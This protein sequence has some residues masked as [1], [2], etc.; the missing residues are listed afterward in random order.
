LK[1]WRYSR[2]DGS[3]T[4]FSLDADAAL[5]ALSDLLMEGLSADEALSWMERG[6]FDLAGLDMRV[7]GLDE[8]LAELRDEQRRLEQRYRLDEADRDLRRRL[9]EILDRE[10]RAQRER[11]GYESQRMNEF[12]ER[13]H[14]ESVQRKP[15]EK[16]SEAIERFRD[17][18]FADAEAGREFQALLDELDRLR[19]LEQFVAQRGRRFRGS[20]AADYQTAQRIRERI[21]ALEQLARDLAAGNFETLDA[22]QLRELLSESGMRSLILIRDLRS[23][24]E[25][26]GY[27]RDRDGNAELTP[28]AIRRIGAQALATV[29]GALRK[30]RPGAHETTQQ[31]IAVPR[32]DE[33]RPWQFGDAFDVDVVKS[34]L[35]AVK[36]RSTEASPSNA[37]RWST[38][39]LEVREK[40][41]HTQCTTVLLLDMSWSM[42]WAGRFPAAKRVALALDHLIRTRWP[43]DHFFVVGFSTRARRLEIRELPEASWDMGEPFTNLQ[44]GLMLAERLIARHPSPSAQVLV[45]TDGQPTAYF[46]GRELRV[47]WPMGFGGVSP[48]AAAETLKQVRRITRRGVTINTFMLDASPELVSFVEQMTR[49]NKGRALYTQPSR[50]GSYVMVDYLSRRK[51]ARK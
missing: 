43:R 36:R 5:D 37:I 16:L 49:I 18:D 8:L 34:L 41:F 31:G 40:D 38:D 17:W 39:D 27:L 2:W 32:P 29:Y 35:N 46:R 1:V 26:A 7:M 51:T 45:I 47:E 28:R 24:L 48:H 42:S 20:E 50:L 10:E 15:S 44:E 6:G 30:G 11:H 9:D 3:Q 25:R 19:Q 23:S 21:E 22:E 4:P 33:T 13:R 14:A 12:K